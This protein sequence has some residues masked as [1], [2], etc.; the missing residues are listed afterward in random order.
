MKNTD[1]LI[2]KWS[3]EIGINPKQLF[4]DD[5]DLLRAISIATNLLKYDARLLKEEQIETLRTF[6]QAANGKDRK[7][8]TQ[9]DC[10]KIMNIGKKINRKLFKQVKTHKWALHLF[11]WLNK[12]KQQKTEISNSLTV[13]KRG[14]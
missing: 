3:K 7:K 14:L 2:N 5:I 12:R 1:K 6:L 11:I 4:V 10:F 13:Q 8:I 9:K